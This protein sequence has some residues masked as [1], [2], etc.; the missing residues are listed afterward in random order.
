M[1]DKPA[2]AH[3]YLTWLTCAGLDGL[4][5]AVTDECSADGRLPGIYPAV[6]GHPVHPAGMSAPPG[7]WCSDCAALTGT[8][9][10]TWAG[11]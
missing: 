3:P 8:H 4:H 2:A 5:H 11:T 9:A 1:R 6:C 7:P 10:R